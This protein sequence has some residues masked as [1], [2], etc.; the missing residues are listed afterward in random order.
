MYVHTPQFERFI[1]SCHMAQSLSLK[2][3][4]IFSLGLHHLQNISI[5]IGM[6]PIT[7]KKLQIIGYVFLFLENMLFKLKNTWK[8]WPPWG[9]LGTLIGILRQW[10]TEIEF[11]NANSYNLLRNDRLMIFLQQKVTSA[12]QNSGVSFRLSANLNC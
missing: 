9:L 7:E 2:R 12:L 4:I 1:W 10:I 3:L 8:K 5:W 11:K 6:F